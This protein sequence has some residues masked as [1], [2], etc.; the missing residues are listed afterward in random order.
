MVSLKILN[1]YGNFTKS[2]GETERKHNQQNEI[3]QIFRKIKEEIPIGDETLAAA[4]SSIPVQP[5]ELRRQAR[6]SIKNPA[7]AAAGR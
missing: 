4:S 1:I 5:V 2:N 6:R 7:V 3:K